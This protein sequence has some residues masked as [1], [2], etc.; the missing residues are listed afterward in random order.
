MDFLN[1]DNET[2]A[3][4]LLG[5]SLCFQKDSIS[6]KEKH[7]IIT[8]TEYYA[9]SDPASHAFRGKRTKRNSSMFLAAGHLYVY[10]IYGMYYCVNIVTSPQDVAAA[11]LIRGCVPV[12]G[13]AFAQENRNNS[14]AAFEICNGPGKLCQALLIDKKWDAVYLG[15]NPY[16]SLQDLEI[17]TR[18]I[19]STTRVGISEAK[20]KKW[21]FILPKFKYQNKTFDYN[22]VV[23]A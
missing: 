5:K 3:R 10:L 20:Q 6:E 4:K 23:K 12:E 1:I 9:E 7:F 19:V 14:E 16:L 15:N 13:L 22:P 21:R 18:G 2:V 8:E 17:P 11:V